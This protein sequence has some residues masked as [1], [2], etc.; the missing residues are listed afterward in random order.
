MHFTGTV[1]RSPYWETFA[2]SAEKLLT[3]ISLIK[4]Y[5]PNDISITKRAVVMRLVFFYQYV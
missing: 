4:K 3:R 2:L 1:Y 5:L